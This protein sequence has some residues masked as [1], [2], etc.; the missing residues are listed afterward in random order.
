MKKAKIIKFGSPLMIVEEDEPT[1]IPYNYAK[2]KIVA[3]G[4]C[5]TDVKLAYGEGLRPNLPLVP[6]HE[7]AGIVIDINTEEKEFLEIKG[8]Q[9]VIYP[10][11]SC[12]N[13]ENC[14]TG[15]EN[16]CL[17]IKGSLGINVDGALQE[18]IVLAL[19]NLIPLPS[20]V[21]IEEGAL[22]GGVVSVP[23][24][25]IREIGDLVGKY[26]LVIGTGG[27]AFAAIQILKYGGAYVVTAGRKPEKL[28]IALNLGSDA[29]IDTNEDYISKAR[30]LTP[31]GKG[32][33]AV[34]DLAGSSI[35]VLRS[36]KTLKRGG[37]F[38]MIG[39]SA[40]QLNLDYS[41]IVLDGI[42]IFGSRSYT[43]KDL[44]DSLKLISEGKVK[45]LITER[46]GLYD[47]NK[48]ISLVKEG[49]SVGRII[50]RLDKNN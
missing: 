44:K 8:K 37:L 9:V 36:I 33:D 4:I 5:G 24:H 6:G 2:V 20:N 21:G 43:R 30:A 22:A 13:C 11:L 25:G 3:N 40:E 1:K 7:P 38:I 26:V 34:I 28:Q 41:K 10:H 50:I 48:A 12:G 18:Y 39:Y 23:L 15:K 27:L 32:F 29:I 14:I 19:R 47:I 16:I 46:F 35:E 31:L 42:K 49:K 45:P 17:N